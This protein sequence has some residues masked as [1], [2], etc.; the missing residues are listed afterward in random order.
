MK[1]YQALIVLIGLSCMLFATTK[2][3][4]PQAVKYKY[5][6]SPANVSNDKVQAAYTDFVTRLY[7]ESG[8]KA[9]IKWDQ[10]DKTVSEGIGYGMMI[11]VYMD[12]TTNNTQSKFDKLWK[13]YNSFLNKNRLMNWK[14]N[15][16]SSV[17]ETNAATDA[18]L[19]VAVGL[20]EAYKQ[21][22][23]EKYLNDA[24]VLIDTISKLEINANGY[25]K[26]GDTWDME[27]NC[28]YFST[29]SLELFKKASSFDWAKV[30]TNSYTLM[31]KARN[32]TT[33]L[34]PNWCSEQGA[35][36]AYLERGQFRYD[37]IRIPWRMA[38]TY[39]WYGHDDAKT[40]CSDMASWITTKTSGDP[41]KIIDGYN[42]DGTPTATDPK[43]QYNNGTFVGCFASAGMVE[44]KHQAWLDAAYGRLADTLVPVKEMYFSQSL[45]L[46]NLMLMSGNMPDFW[47]MPV[48][49]AS[50][51]VSG[52][53]GKAP[54]I[55]AISFDSRGAILNASCAHGVFT[56]DI[57]NS[58]GKRV[59]NPYAGS[60]ASGR[61]SVSLGK[62]LQPGVY[63]ARLK[64][65]AGSAATRVIIA[66]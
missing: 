60:S 25:I 23:D 20:L 35:P 59:M 7:E 54:V 17:I 45:K 3:P 2:Y 28:S 48:S 49:V 5:G 32:A 36:S 50:P 15:G 51:E 46:L 11:M 13:Y 29:G 37:A 19:D 43:N 12:N 40:I 64:T 56:I 58:S 6:I 31:K 18:E 57:Y 26:P 34:I 65:E 66:R 52:S 4:F 41:G 42:L 14:I 38:W 8:D 22:D 33:G 47:T 27:K 61:T 62:R 30:I 39:C 53:A 24:K 63:W 44:T 10:E 16:F 9:R 1:L 55:P 21:W